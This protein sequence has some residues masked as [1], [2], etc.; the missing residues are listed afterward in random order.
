MAA[1]VDFQKYP[2]AA[3]TLINWVP[4]VQGGIIRRQGFRILETLSEAHCMHSFQSNRDNG[5]LVNGSAT[6]FEFWYDDVKV[7]NETQATIANSTFTGTPGAVPTSWT[8]SSTGTATVVVATGGSSADFTVAVASSD[9]AILEQ[10]LTV[11]AGTTYTVFVNITDGTLKVD[12]GSTLGSNDLAGGTLNK[13]FHNFEITPTSTNAHIRLTSTSKTVTTVAEFGS[14]TTGADLTVAHSYTLVQLQALQYTQSI[15][16]QFVAT[17]TYPLSSIARRGVDAFGWAEEKLING[18]YASYNSDETTLSLSAV[19]GEVTVTASSEVFTDGDIGRLLH[20]QHTGQQESASITAEN[21]FSDEILVDGSGTFRRIVVE[22][23]TFAGGTIVTLQRSFDAPG[24]WSDVTTYTSNTNTTYDDTLD[25]QVI[26][27]RIGVKTGE[28]GSGT[29]TV[30]LNNA[31][32]V[33]TGEG[34]ITAVASPTSATVQVID[35]FGY[36]TTTTEVWRF[37][38]YGGDQGHPT[39]CQL[40]EGRLWLGSKQYVE[41]SV[42]DDFTNFDKSTTEDD[43]SIARLVDSSVAWMESIDELVVGCLNQEYYGLSQLNKVYTPND[44]RLK[45]FTSEGSKAIQAVVTGLSGLFVHRDSERVMETAV[46]SESERIG[47][48]S[49]ARLNPKVGSGGI[50]KVALQKSPEIRLWALKEDGQLII[51]T[52]LREEDVVGWSRVH[53]NGTVA[54]FSIVDGKGYDRIYAEIERSNGGRYLCIYDNENWDV[55]AQS[56]NLDFSYTPIA[57]T[58]GASRISLS[59]GTFSRETGYSGDI[60]LTAV[61][62]MFTA[63]D[64][65]KRV[66]LKD[67]QGVVGTYTSTTEIIV[68]IDIPIEDLDPVAANNWYMGTMSTAVTGLIANDVVYGWADAKEIGPLTADGS[69][70]LTLATAAAWV[71]LGQRP[72]AIFEGLKLYQGA[73]SGIGIAGVKKKVNE[74]GFVLHRTANNIEIGSMSSNTSDLDPLIIDAINDIGD[75]GSTGA[76]FTGEVRQRVDG[77]TEF[78]PRIRIVAEKAGPACILSYAPGH[79]VNER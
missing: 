78:D 52:Y 14:G 45:K 17:P 73:Q 24:S 42:S 13:G 37:G 71:H 1:R 63:G 53:V 33:A 66:F 29:T 23:T 22:A 58:P 25:N 70:N 11:V 79:S 5:Y 55:P 10:T 19:D 72:K 74:V 67:G 27:Y 7:V 62:A 4:M 8:D 36:A 51:L 30:S 9:K 48:T 56:N 61:D 26:Y 35:P 65:G 21:V 49:M 6:L 16:L 75:I 15:D 12:I 40:H 77:F 20:I 50:K 60:T 2:L 38:R 41:G 32:G 64:V 44:F 68:A 46:S 3:K 54:D 76:V 47:T 28:Y 39:S 57:P 59:G 34:T 31:S 43:K 69:G 18:P